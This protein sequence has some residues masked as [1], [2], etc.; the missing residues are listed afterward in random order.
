MIVGND[1]RNLPF[2]GWNR[3]IRDDAR[4]MMSKSIWYASLNH[5]SESSKPITSVL[6]VLESVA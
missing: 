2:T 3:P 6:I 5:A 4:W 1:F